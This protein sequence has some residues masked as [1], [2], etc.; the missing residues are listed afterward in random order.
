MQPAVPSAGKPA[1]VTGRLLHSCVLCRV[2]PCTRIPAV[3][4]RRTLAAL[5][6]E[7]RQ[8]RQS[9]M[10]PQTTV[11]P[12]TDAVDFLA[13]KQRHAVWRARAILAGIWLAWAASGLGLVLPT[14]GDARLVVLVIWLLT[15]PIVHLL[16]RNIG[17]PWLVAVFDRPIDVTPSGHPHAGGE[18]LFL[19]RHELD[20]LCSSLHVSNLSSFCGELREGAACHSPVDAIALLD[21]LLASQQLLPE[22]RHLLAEL[23]NLRAV[24]TAAQRVG[25]KFCLLSLGGWSNLIEANLKLY[26][27]RL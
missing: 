7:K 5:C 12:L 10:T 15:A 16:S 8:V 11:K 23:E 22:R 1:S 27:P 4:C 17:S 24:L 14:T 6:S 3:G 21:T 2:T 26:R 25:A 20:A 19:F 13:A 9:P 18:A